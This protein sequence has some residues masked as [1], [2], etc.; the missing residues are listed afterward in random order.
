MDE[1]CIICRSPVGTL[2]TVSAKGLNT[3]LCFSKKRDETDIYAALLAS[4]ENNNKLYV[5]E[6]CRKPFTIH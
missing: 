3:L 6:S 2:A 5:H 1:V 4:Q